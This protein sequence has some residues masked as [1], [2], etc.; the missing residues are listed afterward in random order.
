MTYLCK[1]MT[2]HVYF[3]RKFDIAADNHRVF[4]FMPGSNRIVQGSDI[5]LMVPHADAG[6]IILVGISPKMGN[7]MLNDDECPEKTDRFKYFKNPSGYVST[8]LK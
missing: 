3:P 5:G 2:A 1:E 6:Q 8:E 4:V 7:T